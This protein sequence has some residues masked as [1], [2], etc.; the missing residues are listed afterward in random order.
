MT[1]TFVDE[2]GDF[3]LVRSRLHSIM[4]LAR[5][6]ARWRI[7]SSLEFT[8]QWID[9]LAASVADGSF[10][11][12]V[13]SGV[14]EPG[15]DRPERILARCIDLQGKTQL[16][17]TLRHPTKDVTRNFP[18]NEGLS[19]LHQ[20]LSGSYRN[21]LLCTVRRDWQLFLPPG[22]KPKLVSHKPSTREAPERGHDR[23]RNRLLDDSATDWLQG[24][25]VTDEAGQVRDRMADKYRQ[26]QRY[27]EIL[28]HLAKDCGWTTETHSLSGKKLVIADMG[29]GKGYLTFGAWQLF[30][31]QLRRPVRVLGVEARPELVKLTDTLAQEINATGLKFLPGTI[32]SAE[33]PKVD[34][35]I[36]LHACNIATDHAL[37]RGIELGAKL[38]VVAPCCH[39]EVRSQ[40]KPAGAIASVLHH[41][42]MEE[43]LAEWATD[44]LRALALE[45][46]G[47]RTK[48]FEFVSLE[49]TAKNL[50][51][52]AIREREPFQDEAAR[53]RLLDFKNALG[54]RHQALDI[55]LDRNTSPSHP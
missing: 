25:G 48:V 27:L 42:L 43:R 19:W 46:A 53:Q 17:F 49:H 35:L 6:R 13:L 22:G 18:V 4:D 47:Y 16:S 24:L 33:L 29:C 55:L 26:I 7:M 2:H 39:Q 15:V 32:E 44:G 11:R 5:V 10:V 12:L 1:W 36:A 50:M 45:W 28:S 3:L 37:L 31:R 51:I 41:G 30:H 40:L 23:E 54:I 52:S 8:S 14:A 34:A 38:I 20:E 21:A 9:K